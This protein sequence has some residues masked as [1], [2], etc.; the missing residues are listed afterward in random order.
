GAT[1]QPGDLI[2]FLDLIYDGSNF[3]IN[4]LVASDFQRV[5]PS[6]TTVFVDRSIGS[7]TLYDGTSATISGT[8]GPWRHIQ[9][10]ANQMSTFNLNG[11]TATIQLGATGTYSE[12]LNI[13]AP[14]SGTLIIRGN[15]AS[16]S[17]YT[18]SG[19]PGNIAGVIGVSSGSVELT[20]VTVQNISGPA[21]SWC[22]E[23]SNAQLT[24]IN[25]TLAGA[26]SSF[27][28]ALAEVAGSLTIGA[29][30]IFSGSTQTAVAAQHG[31]SITQ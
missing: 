25:V 29:G 7:D 27:T 31:G 19:T 2:G 13:A 14:N 11:N 24:L 16:Q 8:H 22:V 10:A 12:L 17:S 20:G 26:A 18:I 30:V 1:V 28:C 5:L 6:N 21:I 15:P 3:R 9:Y 4:G 23:V